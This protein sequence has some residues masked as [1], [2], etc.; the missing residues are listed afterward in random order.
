MN[1]SMHE[2][3]RHCVNVGY[4]DAPN[5]IVAVRHGFTHGL[6]QSADK[7]LLDVGTDSVRLPSECWQSLLL[8]MCMALEE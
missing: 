1:K 2:V 3:T 7:V 5:Y 6:F 4:L 8:Y